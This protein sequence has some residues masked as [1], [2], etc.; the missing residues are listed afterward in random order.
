MKLL[1]AAVVMLL[2]P[3]VALA[4]DGRVRGSDDANE[5]FALEEVIVT[6]QKRTQ[7]LQDVGASVSAFDGKAL[8]D[9]GI[10]KSVEFIVAVNKRNV[11][12]QLASKEVIPAQCCG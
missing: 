7:S 1:D 12:E 10:I 4:Q 2:T 5:G 8:E 9:L 6:A 3:G 11:A